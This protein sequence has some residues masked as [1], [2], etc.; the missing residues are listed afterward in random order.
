MSYSFFFDRVSWPV[1]CLVFCVGAKDGRNRNVSKNGVKKIER[2]YAVVL[3]PNFRLSLLSSLYD[4]GDATRRF[5][6]LFMPMKEK[7]GM[8]GTGVGLWKGT[9]A[10]AE[11]SKDVSQ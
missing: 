10:K 7:R 8:F 2:V 5:S 3:L 4:D 6:Q 9:I 11:R 1:G